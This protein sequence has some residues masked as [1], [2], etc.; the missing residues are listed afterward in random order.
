M[1]FF[2][3]TYVGD[4]NYRCTFDKKT[5]ADLVIEKQRRA[6]DTGKVEVAA[7]APTKSGPAS[8]ASASDVD[9]DSIVDEDDIE[10]PMPQADKM[11]R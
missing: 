2:V 10:E 3:L 1:R 6:S 11:K 9:L 7:K 5:P 8:N 4:M